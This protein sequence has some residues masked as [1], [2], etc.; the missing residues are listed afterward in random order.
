MEPCLDKYML[1]VFLLKCSFR[2]VCWCGSVV[3]ATEEEAFLIGCQG[4]GPA[5]TRDF[6]TRI[7]MWASPMWRPLFHLDLTEQCQ[8]QCRGFHWVNESM[9]VS[10][11]ESKPGRIW[12][13]FWALML[14]G[15]GERNNVLRKDKTPHVAERRHAHDYFRFLFSVERAL[16]P[17]D[18]EL[19]RIWQAA[20]GLWGAAAE[21]ILVT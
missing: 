2:A 18:F 13:Q 15:V 9:F 8:G 14:Y 19:L 7:F 20:L 12:H 17:F 11:L 10:V 1:Y 21:F 3:R 5:I 4:K 16:W 6:Y